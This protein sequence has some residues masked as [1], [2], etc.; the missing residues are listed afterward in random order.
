MNERIDLIRRGLALGANVHANQALDELELEYDALKLTNKMFQEEIES[1]ISVSHAASATI[2]RL[3]KENEVA[4]ETIMDIAH[5]YVGAM[6][7]IEILE[8][9]LKRIANDSRPCPWD[10]DHAAEWWKHVASQRREWAIEAVKNFEPAPPP[11]P[12][13]KT[14]KPPSS[15][16]I[17]MNP[18]DP[19]REGSYG[20]FGRNKGWE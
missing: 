8:E 2:Q 11:P 5:G 10:A 17:D 3:R 15:F 4:G 19:E 9:V 7:R 20:A 12:D 14:P 13:S 18:E 16:V 6:Q 1:W